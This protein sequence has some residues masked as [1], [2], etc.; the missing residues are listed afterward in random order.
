MDETTNISQGGVNN[1]GDITLGQGDIT[2]RDK[3]THIAN[4]YGDAAPAAL[5]LHQLPAPPAD[6]TGRVEE[7]ADLLTLLGVG[8]GV[9][10]S[11]LHGIGGVGKTA[12][13]LK[14][15][16]QIKDRYLDAQ[17]FLDLR[18]PS[19]SPLSPAD[20]MSHVIRAYYP[21]NKLPD[22]EAEL[23]ALYLSVLDGKRALLLMDN[24]RDA[25]QVA[26]LKPPASCCLLVTSRNHFHLPGLK[27]KS[28]DAMKAEEAR[29]LL[30]RIV[31]RLS[32]HPSPAGAPSAKNADR[33]GSGLPSPVG[34]V[35]TARE[36]GL[37]MGAEAADEIARLCGY[38]PLALTAAASLLA[39]TED[40]DPA[41]FARQ[42]G[43]ER[44]RLELTGFTAG[45]LETSIEAS[46]NLSY[47]R[48]PS[49]TA[50]VF[51]ALAVFPAD[52]EALAEE[53][54][55]DDAD[56]KHLSDLVKR[57]LTRYDAEKKRYSLHDLARLF[58]NS[59]LS[60]AD[61]ATL[62]QRHA[63]HYETVL[64][65]A[66]ELYKKGG[67]DIKQGLT[68]FDA[69]RGNIEAGQAW[70]VGQIDN[71]P[72]AAKLCSDYA[73]AGVYVLDLRL[74]PREQIR[75]LEA[76]LAAARKLKDRQA[77]GAWLGNLGLAWA[78]LGDTRKAIEFYEQCLTILGEIGDRRSEGT[79]LGNLGIA[80][81]NLGETRKAIEFYEQALAIDREIGD[82]RSEGA[83]LGNLGNA[84]ANLGETCKAIEYHEQQLIIVRE[85]GDRRG[86][87]NA[88]G[89]LGTAWADLGETRKAIEYHEQALAIDREIGDRRGEGQDLGSLGIAYYNLGETRKAIEFYEQHLTIAREIGDRRGE[90]IALWN[91]SLA[92]DKLGERTQAI[93]QAEAAL[94]IKEEIEDPWAEKVRKRLAEWR[95]G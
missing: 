80:H 5:S 74:H 33:G 3:I 41:D 60:A 65:A 45:G 25:A 90:S 53:A 72:D 2:G 84:W 69:E 66:K 13:A 59:R 1:S 4:Y 30:V 32:P 31:P 44:A 34:V 79:M 82:R 71:L 15:A 67:D 94:K 39:E 54:I 64:R 88:L 50:R 57:S 20:A 76:A 61:R 81:K 40:L 89:N 87:G 7:L 56:H 78:D 91:M 18:G 58:A 92:L 75:W 26:P 51:C 8:Q 73:D 85:I 70:A 29:A 46:L 28:L 62:Q 19:D 10:L 22:S 35:P 49:E 77:E 63:T 23:S 9:T 48:L 95:E 21:L 68:A 37:G 43:D 6:F 38:L 47:A 24:A 93:A 11:G 86:E 14:L 83:A 27:S 52:F 17:F 42:L 12:L 36:R 55:C 16:E